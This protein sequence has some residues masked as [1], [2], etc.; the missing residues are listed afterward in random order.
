MDQK[1]LCYFITES[2]S[3]T[4]WTLLTWHFVNKYFISVIPQE[5]NVLIKASKQELFV[6]VAKIT[7]I[8][9]AA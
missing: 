3:Y 5:L 8:L 6:Y 7:N 9:Y 2:L 1:G 4:R